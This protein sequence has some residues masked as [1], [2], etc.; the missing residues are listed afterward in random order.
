MTQIFLHV[1]IAV[2]LS[3]NPADP[4]QL[5]NQAQNEIL[6]HEQ[7]TYDFTGF[8]PSPMGTID[9]IEAHISFQKNTNSFM[10]YDFIVNRHPSD[11]VKINGV[12]KSVNHNDKTVQLFPEND[13]IQIKYYVE[14]N[15]NIIYS[16]ISLLRQS[17]WEYRRDTL[18]NETKLRTYFKV[19]S[20]T[21][22]KGNTIYSEVQIFLNP[23]SKLLERLERRNYFKGNLSQT[24]VFSY[25]DY[26]FDQ[27]AE[28]FSYNFPADYKSV[29]YGQK[30]RTPLPSIGDKAPV[31]SGSDLQNNPLSLAD[32][33]GKKVLLN[34]SVIH[35][36]YCKLTVDYFDELNYQFPDDIQVISVNPADERNKV[37]AYVDKFDIKVPVI[38]NAQEMGELYGVSAY[39]TF[40]LIDE[41]GKIE[42]VTEGYDKAFLSS[43]LN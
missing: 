21:I 14:N 20:D 24:L 38:F 31:F 40:F 11:V 16:P 30:S 37:V 33:Q 29:L 34:F 22:V 27:A 32:Y 1:L 23:A 28:T 6:S 41:D 43:V 7:F 18:I 12:L 42:K 19:E 13:R 8:Y 25:N 36:G 15:R 4:D 35:C 9:T 10:G 5:L 3:T 2:F 26:N 17:G 39:P